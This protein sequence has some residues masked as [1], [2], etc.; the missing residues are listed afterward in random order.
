[1]SDDDAPP[2]NQSTDARQKADKANEAQFGISK[3]NLPS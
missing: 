1:M 2:L 3:T